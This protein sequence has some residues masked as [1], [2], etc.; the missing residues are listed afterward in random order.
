MKEELIKYLE[1]VQEM[2]KA[3]RAY[4]NARRIHDYASAPIYL[5]KSKKLEHDV[6]QLI[7]T[8][9]NELKYGKEQN[10]F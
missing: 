4:F 9:L 5:E 3:Q 8:K 2:R 7:Q 6:D 10:L 1:K